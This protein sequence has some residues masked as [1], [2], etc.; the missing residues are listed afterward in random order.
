M[1]HLIEEHD[2]GYVNGTTWHNM[3]QYHQLDRAPTIEEAHKVFDFETEKVPLFR[4]ATLPEHSATPTMH[5]VKGAYAIVRTDTDNVLVPNVGNRFVSTD[6]KH[7]LNSLEE[8]VLAEYPSLEIESVG[9]LR[10]GATVFLNIKINEFSI[11]GDKSTT[12]NRL[13]Y[14]NPLGLGSYQC[15]AH[16]VRIVCNNTAQA[17][18]AQA[19]ANDSAHKI[20]HTAGGV[21]KINTALLDLGALHLQLE[22]ETDRL[23]ALARHTIDHGFVETYLNSILPLPEKDGRARSIA[24][25]ARTAIVRQ[26]D[27]DYSMDRSPYSLLQATTYFYDHLST[28]RNAGDQEDVARYWNGLAGAKAKTKTAAEAVLL[29]MIA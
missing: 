21:Q 26:F 1:A 28:V 19:I 23:A 24:D 9:S 15:F 18:L 4:L 25:N 22:K 14:M 16:R 6:N 29:S 5:I 10:N 8:H 20:R 11:P 27:S 2:L 17:A 12:M 13:C 7:L 3:P